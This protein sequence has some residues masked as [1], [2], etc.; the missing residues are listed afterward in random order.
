[1]KNPDVAELARGKSARV[2]GNLVQSLTLLKGQPLA[3]NKDLQEDK[4]SLFDTVDTLLVSFAVMSAMLPTLGFDAER[5]AEMAV[6]GF[7]LATDVADYLAKR[8]VPFR[9]AHA[10]V[11]ALVAR[12]EREGKTFTD[13]SLDEYREAHEAFEAD[14]LEIDLDSALAARSAP[15]GTAPVAVAAQHAAARERLETERLR[16]RSS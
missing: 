4:E 5:G 12:C 7:A 13:L 11:G 15:G 8:G 6:A 9:E 2:L 16:E 10:A 14:V 3:Y 1:K